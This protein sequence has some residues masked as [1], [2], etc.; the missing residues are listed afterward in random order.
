MKIVV[1]KRMG[2]YYIQLYVC[3][4]LL[5]EIQK[6]ML[7]QTM[8]PCVC[9]LHITYS[10]SYQLTLT[11]FKQHANKIQMDNSILIFIPHL[12]QRGKFTI[13]CQLLAQIPEHCPNM[14]FIRITSTFVRFW[15]LSRHNIH[16]L[17]MTNKLVVGT[18]LS[19]FTEVHMVKRNG[20]DKII[21][22]HSEPRCFVLIYNHILIM[23]DSWTFT[24]LSLTE[25]REVPIH[26]LN[27]RSFMGN[28]ID[29]CA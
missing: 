5:D 11:W 2:L 17:L 28:H 27:R 9:K 24:C 10:T 19:I 29:S 23:C 12:R 13:K 20:T 3:S 1:A 6:W 8:D 16:P 26:P 4:I 14:S 7:E 15:N 22:W 21:Q 18:Y 25:W